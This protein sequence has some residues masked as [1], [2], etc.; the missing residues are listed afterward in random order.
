MRCQLDGKSSPK[1]IKN[2]LYRD[3]V[4]PEKLK[5]EEEYL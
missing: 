3:N 4:V 1:Y 5:P 2:A